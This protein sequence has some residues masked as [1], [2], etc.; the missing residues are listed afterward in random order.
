MILLQHIDIADDS[1]VC[2]MNE[3]GEPL[4]DN[5]SKPEKL[6]PRTSLVAFINDE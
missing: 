5:Q 6:A 2:L 4:C 1:Q 3:K